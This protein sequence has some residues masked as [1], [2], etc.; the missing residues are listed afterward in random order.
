MSVWLHDLF[1]AMFLLLWD[2]QLFRT[3]VSAGNGHI[4]GCD[5]AGKG[6]RAGG[7]CDSVCPGGASGISDHADQCS[8]CG[9]H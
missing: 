3:A 9:V 6:K 7:L 5:R 2:C 1:R 8:G 4:S